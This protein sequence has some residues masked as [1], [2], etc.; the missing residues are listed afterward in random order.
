MRIMDSL[1]DDDNLSDLQK[2]VII[3]LYR[4]ANE[5][6]KL[7]RYEEIVNKMNGT[8]SKIN[9][10]K[11]INKI[12]QTNDYIVNRVQKK[13]QGNPY[14][15]ELKKIPEKGYKILN[16][17]YIDMLLDNPAL[18]MKYIKIKQANSIFENTFNQDRKRFVD[19]LDMV[20]MSL[21]DF[22]KTSS[23]LQSL[24]IVDEYELNVIFIEEDGTKLFKSNVQP[25]KTEKPKKEVT[26]AE[27]KI[28]QT[29]NAKT[30]L[31]G[32]YEKVN[33]KSP[34][35]PKEVKLVDN[36]IKQT[37]IEKTKS[38]LDYM[39]A[40]GQVEVK[41]INNMLNE[42]LEFEK[43]ISQVNEK[44]TAPY[45][46]N[47]YYAG[48]GLTINQQTITKEV[49]KV[50][51][52]INQD[53]FENAE[54]IIDYMISK[55]T[56]N[57]NFISSIR[58]EALSAKS[59]TNKKLDV[60]NNP[61]MSDDVNDDVTLCMSALKRADKTFTSVKERYSESTYNNCLKQMK[62]QIEEELKNGKRPIKLVCKIHFPFDANMYNQLF[63]K[64][65]E[66]KV[67]EYLSQFDTIEEEL[68]EIKLW[69]KNQKE[70]AGV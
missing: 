66:Q 36:I 29:E 5:K 48:L 3:C 20:G 57:I 12:C 27:E 21:D 63:G 49:Q 44:G 4:L 6:V 62:N 15:F 38:L 9:L 16:N 39:I 46:L 41:F 43:A 8:I 61:C 26:I 68:E 42:Y 24:G 14:A 30:L 50:Q 67:F 7:I 55:K 69:F 45:L 31:I 28:N 23:K 1:I 64:A 56:A 40:K 51:A 18:L 52:I 35:F 37:S 10:T 25:T 17:K 22:N 47:K 13:V 59:T 11:I 70:K 58:N 34:N 19:S 2:A 53:G 32:F 60:K 65:T 54:K 33:G